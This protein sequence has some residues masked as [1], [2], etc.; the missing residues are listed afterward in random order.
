LELDLRAAGVSTVI[1]ASG[2]SY[3][4]GWV[5]LPVFAEIDSSSRREPIHQCG[6]TNIPG[7]YFI[8]LPWLSKHKSSLM[9]GVGDDAAFLAHHIASRDVST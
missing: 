6:V 8:G 4:F 9:A 2:F 3:D 5:H 1:W 7:L